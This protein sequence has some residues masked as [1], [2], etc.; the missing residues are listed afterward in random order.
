MTRYHLATGNLPAAAAIADAAALLYPASRE[1]WE[2]K[3]AV[4]AARGDVEGAE[5]ARIEAIAAGGVAK[6]FAVP[7]AARA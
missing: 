4:A 5:R 2:A 7:G 3:A 6:P 1:A